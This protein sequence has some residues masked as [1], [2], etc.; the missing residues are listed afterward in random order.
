MSI[1]GKIRMARKGKGISQETLAD[2]LGV[3]TQAV[4]L[5]ERDDN[6]PET[7]KLLALARAL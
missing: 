6:L 4:S 2:M 5:W 3:S 7:R 1:G